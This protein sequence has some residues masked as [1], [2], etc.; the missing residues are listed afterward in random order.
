MRK[1]I[2]S[3]LCMLSSM[4][5]AACSNARDHAD[6]AKS[7]PPE[8][9]AQQSNC[10]HAIAAIS[11]KLLSFE[12][13]KLEPISSS[14]PTSWLFEASR[15]AQFGQAPPETE[16]L[17]VDRIK[18]NLIRRSV[19]RT[20]DGSAYYFLDRGGLLDQLVWFG[21]VTASAVTD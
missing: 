5:G 7:P 6:A 14:D 4:A 11:D 20:C 18:P 15:Q 13:F 12:T 9:C 1:L 10:D 3:A 8:N 17:F 21:P 16:T 19:F 2:F